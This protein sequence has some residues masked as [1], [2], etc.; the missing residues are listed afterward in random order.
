M[1]KTGLNE[2]ERG[3]SDLCDEV[4]KLR[5]ALRR[6][7]MRAAPHKDDTDEDRRRDLRHIDSI[8]R[9]ALGKDVKE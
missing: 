9:A 4:T 3:V 5:D 8:A 6:I 7:A 1:T 2:V